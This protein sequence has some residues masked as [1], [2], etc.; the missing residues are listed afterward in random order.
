[1]DGDKPAVHFS[2]LKKKA[3][4]ERRCELAHVYIC[5]Y[6]CTYIYVYMDMYESIRTRYESRFIVNIYSGK[7]FL[8]AR[9]KNVFPEAF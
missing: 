8:P 9:W 4:K 2:A 3:G 6:V 5:I 1:M 7:Y